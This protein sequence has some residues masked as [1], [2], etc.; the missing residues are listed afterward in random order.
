MTF[1]R[2][3]P[4]E[5]AKLIDE[6]GYVLV[7][8]R[9]VPEFDAGHPK[10]AFNVPLNH[11]GAAGMTPNP[12]FVRVVTATFPK[13]AKLVVACKA[14]GRSMKAATLLV[15]AGFTN[16]VDQRAGWSGAADPFGKGIE[17][18]WHSSGLP[19]A[20]DAE[21]GRSWKELAERATR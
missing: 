18:G 8:V 17:P 1:K 4:T 12:D 10:G 5:A 6:E 16:V 14:G 2:V 13:D 21:A 9:S 15:Q 11:A 19:A 7:D 20:T 3:S